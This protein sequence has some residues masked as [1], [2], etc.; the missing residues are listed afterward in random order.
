MTQFVSPRESFDALMGLGVANL[1]S[2]LAI[3]SQSDEQSESIPSTEGQRVLSDHLRG[4]FA[5]LGCETQQD[6]NA[7]L[8]ATIAPNL[9]DGM[10]A[11][12]LAFMVHIDTSEGTVA[13]DRLEVIEGWDGGRVIYPGNDRLNVSV[14]NY[15]ETRFWQGEDVLHGPGTAPVG[16]DDKLGMAELMTLAQVLAQNPEIPHGEIL[17]IFR[18]DEE[19]GRMA[20]VEGLADML[21]DRGVRHGYTV[22]GLLPHDINTE[23]FN[24]SRARVAFAGAPL[25]VPDGA[26]FVDLRLNG[27]RSHGATA[28]AEGYLNPTRILAETLAA[29]GERAATEIVP[30][31]FASDS[32]DETNADATFMLTGATEADLLGTVQQVLEPHVWRGAFVE[33]VGRSAVAPEGGVTDA[34]LRLGRHLGVFFATE[35]PQPVL[36]EESEGREGYS[37]PFFG[38]V[39]DGG[40]VL[41]YRLR[42]FDPEELKQR[43]DHVRRAVLASDLTEEDVVVTQQYINMGPAMADYPE[44][45]RWALEAVEPLGV[46][47][48]QDPIRGGTGVDPFLV[49]G[50]GVANLGTGYFAPESEKELTSRQTI[51]RHA[52]WLTNLVQ[53]LVTAG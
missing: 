51:A 53:T 40:L 49:R 39:V 34:A 33:V 17:L 27:V 5:D 46:E 37:N 36:S 4:F 7:N 42:S 44:L 1:L 20:A 50:I 31:A 47:K 19:I 18:P 35:G 41:D 16:L 22:D 26:T 38:S 8:I 3:D 15:P 21:R 45:V 30:V 2:V 6:D 29:L 48:R 32:L 9:P 13:V 12:P 23:N 14:A 28:K 24:A 52:L 10:S 11:P 43:E 25:A